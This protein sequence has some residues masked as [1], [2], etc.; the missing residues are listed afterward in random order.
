[1]SLPRR[2]TVVA[3][4]A[5]L[6]VALPLECTVGELIPQLVRLAGAQPQPVG[7][8]PGWGLA[9][10]GEHPLAPGL[11][12]SAAAVADGEVL[13]LRP[14]ARYEAPLLFDDVVDAI[15]SAAETRKGAWR[16]RVGR[17]LAIAVAAVLFLGATLSTLTALSGQPAAPLAAGVVA[18]ALLLLGGALARARG[19]ADA[20]A[21]CSGVGVVAALLAGLSSVPRLVE[22]LPVGLGAATL[23]AALAAA[24]V[25]HRLAAFVAAAT[26]TGLGALGCAV[27]VL[28][29]VRPVDVA[30]VGVVVVTALGA[31]APMISLRLARLPLPRVPA[32][33][34]SFRA[35]ERPALGVDV[36]DQTS[37]AAEMLTGLVAA[38]GAV[39]AGGC[40]VLLGS[41]SVWA[42]VLA[43]LLGLAWVLRSRSYAGAM[44]R[45]APVVAGLLVLTG[46]VWRLAADA[47]TN[48]LLAFAAGMVVTAAACL[49]Y[50]ER[51]VRGEHSPSRARWL[52][53]LEY[54]VLI[55]LLPVA[56]AILGVY[57]AIGG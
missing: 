6:D 11:T 27:V 19:D 23:A 36:L 34:E 10:I 50:A 26:A 40:L 2:V 54:L 12:L 28:F 45:V 24:L 3:P 17:R 38:L 9:R 8:S 31:V 37:A 33:M 1:M 25:G 49:W 44:Q 32:D 13:H 39:V 47:D 18:V 51:V 43:G 30:A 35:D 16:P 15:A 55:A 57:S 41:D 14:R 29:D 21:A 42:L 56:G 52:D 53:V 5:R 22:A 4:R 48:R 20:G 46:L 7:D